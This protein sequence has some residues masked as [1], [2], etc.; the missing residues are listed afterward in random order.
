MLLTLIDFSFH[1]HSFIFV[2][3]CPQDGSESND[4]PTV[5]P[6]IC[7]IAREAIVAERIAQIGD[8]LMET[9]REEFEAAM[10]QVFGET[11]NGESINYVMFRSTV[12][13]MV[14]SAV[15]E[16]Y[17]VSILKCVGVGVLGWGWVCVRGVGARLMGRCLE[18]QLMERVSIMSCL[19]LLFS[20]WSGLLYQSGIM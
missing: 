17:H 10:A 11:A 7:P 16:W 20:T 9:H 8:M 12:Q 6:L 19:G 13:H 15:P 4:S 3:V 2:V 14:R 5:I 1:F 18:R